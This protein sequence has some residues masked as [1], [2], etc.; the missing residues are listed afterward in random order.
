MHVRGNIDIVFHFDGKRSGKRLG[1]IFF[2][3]VGEFFG[4]FAEIGIENAIQAGLPSRCKFAAVGIGRGDD[5][6]DVCF[7][8]G[9]DFIELGQFGT[10]VQ[11]RIDFFGNNTVVA[12]TVG[13]IMG[14]TP[15]GKIEAAMQ[16]DIFYCFFEVD[17]AYDPHFGE[18]YFSTSGAA[19]FIFE[20]RQGRK[21][22][23]RS[24]AIL[25][26]DCICR[27][28]FHIGKSVSFL[29]FLLFLFRL[30]CGSR[31]NDTG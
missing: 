29:F 24:T 28:D 6:I 7:Q 27:E 2:P 30:L 17:V 13:Y 3:F 4:H 31:E 15:Y 14:G 12:Y 11:P 22:P 10:V 25:I 1:C 23:T 19:Y 26:F 9:V 16:A 20:E 18:V 8:Y 21:A 5:S